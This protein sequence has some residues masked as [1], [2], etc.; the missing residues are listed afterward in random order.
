[1]N[2][3]VIRS[4]LVRDPDRARHELEELEKLVRLTIKEART[5]LFELRPLVLETQGLPAALESY[6]EQFEATNSIQVD[7]DLQEDLERMPPA[8]EQ[9]IFSVVQEAMGNARKH[10][11]AQEITVSLR[12][13]GDRIVASVRDDGSGFDVEKTQESYTQRESQSLGL[14]N[15]VERA[16]RI[17]GKL[18]IASTP[19]SGT[20]V[21]ITVPRRHL[22]VRTA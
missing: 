4:V 11:R 8:V 16:E 10:A 1:M 13:E 15:M 20:T 12:M 18:K 17:G 9:T 6:A 3:E 14:V 5:M 19:G 2:I 22:E 7:L 21:S